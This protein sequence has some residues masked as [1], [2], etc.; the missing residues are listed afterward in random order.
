MHGIYALGFII[1]C[2]ELCAGYYIKILII[3]ATT[4]ACAFYNDISECGYDIIKLTVISLPHSSLHSFK[5]VHSFDHNVDSWEAVRSELIGECLVL[6]G[7]LVFPLAEQLSLESQVPLLEM[8]RDNQ[9]TLQLSQNQT[10]V[11]LRNVS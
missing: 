2:R 6:E 1:A 4:H 10:R 3:V 9:E 5:V 11:S 8:L 7:R